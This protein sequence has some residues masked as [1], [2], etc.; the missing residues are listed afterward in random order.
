[1][2]RLAVRERAEAARRPPA[3]AQSR[4]GDNTELE[5]PTL[6]QGKQRSEERYAA[7]E[8]LRPIDWVNDPGCADS[9]G[10]AKLFAQDGMPRPLPVEATSDGLLDL[11]VRLRN[12]RHVGFVLDRQGGRSEV[13]EAD[14]V[15]L[16]GQLER[17]LQIGSEGVQS[18]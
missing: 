3:P 12:G 6:L 11:A 7:D 14:P 5:L 15:G 10:A 13:R 16:V 2:D 9:S 4:R 18:R 1:M 8:A 17:E